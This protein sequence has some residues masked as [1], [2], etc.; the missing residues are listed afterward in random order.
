MQKRPVTCLI[1]ATLLEA[2]PFIKWLSLKRTSLKPFPVY[3]AGAIIAV[4]SGIG[5]ANSAMATAYACLE[6]GPVRLMN[7]G[8]AGATGAAL[9]LGTCLQVRRA[10]ECDRPGL[11][12]NAPH[13]HAPDILEGFSLAVIATLDRPTLAAA[14]R[15]KLSIR[16]QLVDMESAAFIQACRKFGKKCYVFKFVTDTP[17]HT[18]GSDIVSNIKKYRDSFAAFFLQSVLCRF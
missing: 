3:R 2:K 1:M 5:K 11:R 12:S 4:I 13:E 10:I 8:A 9:P 6:F 7:L 17:A 16:T 18:R 15:R 14:E